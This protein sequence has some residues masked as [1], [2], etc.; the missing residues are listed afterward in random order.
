[1]NDCFV[2]PFAAAAAVQSSQEGSKEA[3]K[4]AVIK[5]QAIHLPMGWNGNYNTQQTKMMLHLNSGFWDEEPPLSVIANV[6]IAC[7]PL[8]VGL[9]LLLRLTFLNG[10]LFVDSWL[11]S[12][13]QTDQESRVSCQSTCVVPK[14]P[15]PLAC[16]FSNKMAPSS[17][18]FFLHQS[19]IICQ[20]ALFTRNYCAMPPVVA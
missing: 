11:A 3:N 17:S 6:F 9:P 4:Q 2:V 12:N 13:K 14:L 8:S 1:M 16:L 20:L 15:S 10:P 19:A 7:L 18:S 5:F